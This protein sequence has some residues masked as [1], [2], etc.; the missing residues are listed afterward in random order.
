VEPKDEQDLIVDATKMVNA[1]FQADSEWLKRICKEEITQRKK[2]E[3]MSFL[4]F[5]DYQSKTGKTAIYPEVGQ[6]TAGSISYCA[7]GAAG[8]AGEIANKVKKLLRDDGGTLTPERKEQIRQ[9]IGGVL[10]YL[11]QLCTEIGTT[12]EYAAA[13]NLIILAD[14]KERGMLKGSGDNR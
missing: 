3:Q 1:I 6:H 10:W 13:E 8:E 9:E 11:S 14:R 7:L 5:E 4:T 12:L 2:E